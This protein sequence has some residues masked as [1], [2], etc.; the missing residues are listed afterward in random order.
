MVHIEWNIEG[1]ACGAL[2]GMIFGVIIRTGAAGY[3]SSATAFMRDAVPGQPS[4]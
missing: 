2:S 1:A 4:L 3:G